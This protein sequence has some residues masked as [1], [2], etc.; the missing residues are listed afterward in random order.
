MMPE[1]LRENAEFKKE[2]E[3]EISDAKGLIATQDAFRDKTG[4]VH[5]LMRD[6]GVVLATG[7][8]Y[9]IL[10]SAYAIDVYL[11]PKS[12]LC[13][14]PEVSYAQEMKLGDRMCGFEFVSD[15][16]GVVSL[17]GFRCWAKGKQP[18]KK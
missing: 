10:C 17:V 15:Y 4:T 13:L 11:I 6:K 14:R 1:I 12:N 2:P 3:F 5:M 8:I 16:R 18:L 9:R 7:V